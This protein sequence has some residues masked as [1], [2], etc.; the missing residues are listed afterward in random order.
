MQTSS[1]R[2]VQEENCE[3]EEKRL[4]TNVLPW[5]PQWTAKNIHTGAPTKCTK[6]HWI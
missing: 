4:G 1:A 2:G 3:K 6:F 5:Q